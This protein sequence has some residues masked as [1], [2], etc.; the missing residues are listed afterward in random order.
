[1]TAV[2]FKF[3]HPDGTPVVDAP[4]LVTTRKP[5]FDETLNNGIQVSGDVNGTTDAQGEATL[6]LMAGFATYYLIM[7]NP[8]AVPG[9]DGCTAGL[10]YR[11]MVVE[12]A[13]TLH[14]EDLIVT[15]PTWSRPWDEVALQI[16]IDAKVTATDAADRAEAS[17]VAADASE[18]A[19]KT[20]EDNA[21][22]SE[23]AAKA[24]ELVAIDKAAQASASQVAALASEVAAQASED[25]AAGSA[26]AA[27]ASADFAAGAVVDMQAQVDEATAQ[28]GIATTAANTSTANAALTAADRVATAADAV[29][30]EADK[31]A[32]AADVV[33]ITGLKTDVT[34]LKDETLG[35]RDDAMAAVGTLGAIIQDGGPIDLSGG[36][37]PTA[38]THSTMWKVTV[39]GTVSGPQGDTYGIGDSLFYAKDQDLFYK[40]DNTENVSSVA[41]KTGV[42]TLVK[43]DVGLPL[44]DNTADS[45]KPVSTPQQNAL[46]LKI[47]KTS[48]VDDLTSTDATKVLSAKQGKSLYDLIQA[49]NVTLVVYEFLATAGQTVFSGVD[50]N[51]LTLLYTAGTG[52]IVLRNGVQLEK[53]VDYTATDGSSVTF[54]TAND[55]ND[56]IQVMAFGTFSVA[57]HY[58]KAEDDALLLTKANKTSTDAGFADRYTKA[59][60]DAR[61]VQ[62]TDVIDVA[63]GGT[64]GNTQETARTGLGLKTAA[65]ADILG[66][67]TQTGGVPTGSIIEYT[68]DGAGSTCTRF[69]DGTQVCTYR[70]RSPTV[71]ALDVAVGPMWRTRD[72]AILV[73][74]VNYLKAFVGELPKLSYTVRM[75]SW[76]GFPG[77]VAGTRTLTAWVPA[78]VITLASVST[79]LEI[80]CIAWGRW[81]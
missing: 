27:Q 63:H 68:T 51:G 42:V 71:Y 37:Y 22:L 11:F 28:A 50:A 53:T 52:T 36:T 44:V 16:I 72:T 43:S 9:D 6:E 76:Y 3:S 20:S 45:A 81:F 39:G 55:L 74:G 54:V 79:T 2:L 48:I 31:V 33:T 56:L 69:A 75:D 13:T 14:V 35:Y 59:E 67:V 38:P 80:D 15:T 24:S 47:D 62:K 60:D 19:A 26:L 70:F 57:N 21:K 46:D 17:A 65:V 64:G 78:H 66:T 32:T 18:L 4:F 77:L 34:A 25:A 12:S 23:N 49:N 7:N 29:A 58:T 10:R 5:S 1:M 40:I 41:G 30:T 8:G 61:F 73:S